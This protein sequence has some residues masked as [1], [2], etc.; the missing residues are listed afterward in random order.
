[1]ILEVEAEVHGDHPQ[2]EVQEMDL[3]EEVQL[4]RI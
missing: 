4:H 2:E 3:A 1:M